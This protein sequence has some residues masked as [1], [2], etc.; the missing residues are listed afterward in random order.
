MLYFTEVLYIY[1]NILYG[2][3]YNKGKLA[4]LVSIYERRWALQMVHIY[5]A[6]N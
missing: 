5:I 1:L 3:K 2:C 4:R 6:A